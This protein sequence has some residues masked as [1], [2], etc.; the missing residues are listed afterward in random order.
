[1]SGAIRH[2]DETEARSA[3]AER[4]RRKSGRVSELFPGDRV[5]GSV[6]QI[7]SLFRLSD[8]GTI[9]LRELGAAVLAAE[10]QLTR[11]GWVERCR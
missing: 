5:V 1:V 10:L 4:A 7:F 11:T 3:I 9:V 6:T 8:L 2:R